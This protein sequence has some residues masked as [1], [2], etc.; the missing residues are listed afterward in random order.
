MTRNEGPPV[1][2]E[3]VLVG[4]KQSRVVGTVT[5][6]LES[7]VYRSYRTQVALCYNCT[8]NDGRLADSDM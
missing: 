8:N 7:D 5:A 4:L 3:Q 2:L 1:S 6:P